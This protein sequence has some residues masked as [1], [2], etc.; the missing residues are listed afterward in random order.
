MDEFPNSV[1][2]VLFRATNGP[3]NDLRL[4]APW[5]VG[6]VTTLIETRAFAGKEDWEVFYYESGAER[7]RLLASLPE[8]DRATLG[9]FRLAQTD[10]ARIERLPRALKNL[11]FNFGRSPE[12]L[13]QKGRILYERMQ[14]VGSKITPEQATGCVRFRVI[15]ETWNGVVLRERATVAT[16]QRHFPTLRFEKT[17]GEFDHRYAVDYQVF[18]GETLLT[19]IQIKPRSYAESNASYLLRARQANAA[20]SEAYQRAFGCPV[21]E[22]LAQSNGEILNAGVVER[23]RGF[24]LGEG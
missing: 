5:S 19:G 10:P 7:L 6:Y 12:E 24:F 11:N 1:P 3:W 4:N 20:K 18:C 15:G 13:A 23:L 16:L 21:L 9:D 2:A 17:V 22:V 8:A 14:E